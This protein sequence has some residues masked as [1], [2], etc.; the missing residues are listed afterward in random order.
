MIGELCCHRELMEP[1]CQKETC[2]VKNLGY[3]WTKLPHLYD[4]KKKTRLPNR[5]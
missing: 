4:E 1:R 3:Y 5:T 2:N